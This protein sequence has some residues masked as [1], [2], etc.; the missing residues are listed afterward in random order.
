MQW[1][2]LCGCCVLLLLHGYATA[3]KAEKG[4]PADDDRDHDDTL[5]LTSSSRSSASADIASGTRA[6]VLDPTP[7]KNHAQ[8]ER[9][10]IAAFQPYLYPR[11]D[12]CPA[13][14]SAYPRTTPIPVRGAKPIHAETRP[15]RGGDRLRRGRRP[16]WARCCGIHR[17]MCVQVQAHA[18][19]RPHRCA[20]G[21]APARTRARRDGRGPTSTSTVP[22]GAAAAAIS[23]PARL[24][25]GNI[26]G[27][28]INAY[29]MGFGVSCG[30]MLRLGNCTDII[31]GSSAKAQ[32]CSFYRVS[33]SEAE[34]WES[35]LW[36]SGD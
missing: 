4:S 6:G 8:P 10:A 35:H 9:D 36:I 21:Q 24:R 20:A 27:G 32:N 7:Q 23:A 34:F 3:E 19:E 33:V 16:L 29:P 26:S 5:I 30:C 31:S 18:R 22:I 14:H 2:A 12:P 25:R 28:W 11:R 1:R 17:S 15:V 13:L